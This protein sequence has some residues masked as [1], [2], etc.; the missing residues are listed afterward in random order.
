LCP[1]AIA[2]ITATTGD[3]KEAG[4]GMHISFPHSELASLAC[5]DVE[6]ILEKDSE[7]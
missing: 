5:A 4:M 6:W 1:W 3:L 2:K 7:L